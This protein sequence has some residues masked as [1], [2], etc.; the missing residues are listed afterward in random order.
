MKKAT[1]NTFINVLSLLSFSGLVS[2]GNL[3]AFRLPPGSGQ[4][5]ILG[6]T[7]HQWGDLHLAIA[8]AFLCFMIAHLFQ[9][10]SWI[11]ARF[12]REKENIS[13]WALRALI[14]LLSAVFLILPIAAPTGSFSNSLGEKN[15]GRAAHAEQRF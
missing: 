13:A 5:N 10:R 4:L 8:I 15:C 6:L 3:M 11:T 14:V 7:R 9:H 12:W 1:V 2:T